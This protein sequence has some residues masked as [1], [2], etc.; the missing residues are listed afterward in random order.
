V[1]DASLQDTTAMAMSSNFHTIIRNRIVDE[2]T[3]N[4]S[5]RLRAGW[6]NPYLIVFRSELVQALLNDVISVQV[7]DENN[8]MQAQSQ[9]NGMNLSIVSLI[10]LLSPGKFEE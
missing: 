4:Q 5:E 8:N 1:I 6:N 3:E 2:L 10:S 7:L 9:N